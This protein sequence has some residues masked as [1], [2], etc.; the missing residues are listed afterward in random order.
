ML[1]D[2]LGKYIDNTSAG[3][4]KES[5]LKKQELPN[6]KRSYSLFKKS[7][8]ELE[9][10]AIVKATRTLIRLKHSLAADREINDVLP[11][12]IE[13]FDIALQS[14]ELLTLPVSTE[15]NNV[16]SD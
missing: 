4:S 11:E 14:G 13:Q 9:R 3:L 7:E 8:A 15:I 10:S 12:R 5:C 16:R 1:V 2:Q 6:W